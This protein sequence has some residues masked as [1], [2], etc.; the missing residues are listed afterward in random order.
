MSLFASCFLW[1]YLQFGKITIK[2]SVHILMFVVTLFEC[3]ILFCCL[4]EWMHQHI[5]TWMLLISHCFQNFDWRLH[6]KASIF[7]LLVWYDILIV[8]L[9]GMKHKRRLKRANLSSLLQLFQCRNF[10][11]WKASQAI[12][13]FANSKEEQR[14]VV[15]TY[16]MMMV[17][18]ECWILEWLLN[19]RYE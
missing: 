13:S 12:F 5:N 3:K 9:A 11:W 2:E 1:K 4:T 18:K 10:S 19:R 7:L 16:Q 14:F 8:I 15:T 17:D 6:T